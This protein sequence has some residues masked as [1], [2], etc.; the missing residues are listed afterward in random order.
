[1][2][3]WT[4]GPVDRW[5]GNAL[6]LVALALAT[7]MNAQQIDRAVRPPAAPRPSFKFPAVRTHTLANGLRLLVV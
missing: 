6:A 2:S 4:G 7:R 3:R 1:V 5:T